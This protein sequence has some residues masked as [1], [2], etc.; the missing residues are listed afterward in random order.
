LAISSGSKL[1]KEKS[2]FMQYNKA[3][4]YSSQVGTVAVISVTWEAEL[5]RSQ[6]KASLGKKS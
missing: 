5:G 3:L 2:P 4:K 6:F 1:Q